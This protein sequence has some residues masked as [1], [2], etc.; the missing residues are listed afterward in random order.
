MNAESAICAFR[1]ANVGS[2]GRLE[3]GSAYGFHLRGRSST[4]VVLTAVPFANATS[5]AFWQLGG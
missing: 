2:S 1:G 3:R 5:G 4:I